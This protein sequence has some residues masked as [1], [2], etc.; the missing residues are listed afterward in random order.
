MPTRWQWAWSGRMPELFGQGKGLTVVGF[1]LRDV[2]DR[3]VRSRR[4]GAGH[5]L[6]GPVP[7]AHEPAP[8]CARR[9]CVPPPFGLP[10]TCASLGR[11][12]IVSESL[13]FHRR[14]LFQCLREQ[15]H[16]IGDAQRGYRPNL[17]PPPSRGNRRGDSPHDRCSRRVQQ[18]KRPGQLT[19]VERQHPNSPTSKYQAHRVRRPPRQSAALRPQRPCP[20]RTYPARHGTRQDTHGR[21]P[22]AETGGQSAR[23]AAPP[24]RMPGSALDSGSPADNRPGCDRPC[25]R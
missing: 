18:G 14:G 6:D 15:R 24:R 12:D 10:E 23:G 13:C 22:Q 16:G 11:D 3:A 21:T 4:G 5:T 9:G 2:G 17:R 19:L 1:G 7:G 25:P 8:A 20:R